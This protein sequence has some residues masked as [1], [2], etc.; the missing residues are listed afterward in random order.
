CCESGETA[1][2]SQ[3]VGAP[4]L[5][6][7]KSPEL[8]KFRARAG[9]DNGGNSCYLPDPLEPPALPGRFPTGTRGGRMPLKYWRTMLI[10]LALGASGLEVWP[11]DWWR[12]SA[13]KKAASKA[14]PVVA[15]A[16]DVA[17]PPAPALP[18]DP[19]PPARVLDLV[20]APAGP[21]LPI[22]PPVVPP[23]ITP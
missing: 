7:V 13:E 14:A 10:A 3:A 16:Q 20:P 9:A 23:Q 12:G 17:A 21:S 8:L 5:T 22:A 1:R 19:E 2:P 15:R 4:G 6:S 18:A 11:N